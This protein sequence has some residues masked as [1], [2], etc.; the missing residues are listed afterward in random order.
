[1]NA[2]YDDVTDTSKNRVYTLE[3]AVLA[4]DAGKAVERVLDLSLD[5]T[6]VA[7]ENYMLP[8]DNEH[9]DLY[10]YSSWY[11]AHVSAVHG[12]GFHV[13]ARAGNSVSKLVAMLSGRT[14]K[15]SGKTMTVPSF[16]S[17]EELM[18]KLGPF[19]EFSAET[20]PPSS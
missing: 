6:D 13:K 7:E 2:T 12:K 14:F 18:L 8:T 9:P 17:Y 4:F 20:Y 19:P 11:C 15:S 1:M 3:G 5:D 10:L 16:S